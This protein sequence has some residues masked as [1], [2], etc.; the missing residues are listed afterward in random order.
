MVTFISL[1]GWCTSL[2]QIGPGVLPTE[3]WLDENHRLLVVTS[4]NKAYILD[5]TIAPRM[6]QQIRS[7]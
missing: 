3:Y 5:D 2:D 4:L 6:E 7:T 1:L